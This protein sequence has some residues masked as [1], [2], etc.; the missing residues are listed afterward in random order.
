M[1]L[2]IEEVLSRVTYDPESGTFTSRGR[3]RHGRVIG[4]IDD[5]GYVRIDLGNGI[6]ARAHRL[7]WLLTHG[8]PPI[9]EIDHIDGD[10]TNNRINN[11][12]DVSRAENQHNR[13]DP[14]RDA[15]TAKMIGVSWDNICHGWKAQIQIN[16]NKIHL[17]YHSTPE[18]AA[19]AYRRAKDRLHPTHM[20]MRDAQ[21]P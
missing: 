9:G 21:T 15:R 10:K 1:K 7:A 2:T 11:L 18:A 6:K 20:R 3:F 14:K 17:G 16:G 13:C 19:E 12:R 5:H 4:Y 8:R